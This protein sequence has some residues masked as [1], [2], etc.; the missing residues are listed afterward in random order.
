MVYEQSTIS[1][2]YLVLKYSC[3]NLLVVAEGQAHR[4]E[5]GRDELL[6]VLD[7]RL[8]Q[9]LQLGHFHDPAPARRLDHLLHGVELRSEDA[10]EAH[11]QHLDKGRLAAALAPADDRHEVELVPRLIQ[12]GDRGDAPDPGEFPVIG[13]VCRL[14]PVDE[15]GIDARHPVPFGQVDLVQNRVEP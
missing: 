7:L 8:G 9:A 1:V 15:K 10:R 2:I 12:A 13:V 4:V 14:E 11:R 6:D 5:R 3:D